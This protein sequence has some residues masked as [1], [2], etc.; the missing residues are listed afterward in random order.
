MQH[1]KIDLVAPKMD[2]LLPKCLNQIWL[3]LLFQELDQNRSRIMVAHSLCTALL[4]QRDKLIVATK[5]PPR[6]LKRPCGKDMYLA[7]ATAPNQI[8]LPNLHTIWIQYALHQ[9]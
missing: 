5:L 3:G 8:P 2:Q 4:L 6:I 9:Q 1:V 7:I